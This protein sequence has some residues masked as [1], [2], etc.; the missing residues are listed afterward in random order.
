M[1]LFISNI[2]N[3]YTLHLETSLIHTSEMVPSVEPLHLKVY[4][5]YMDYPTDSSYVAM[6]EMPLEGAATGDETS[7]SVKSTLVRLVLTS[8]TFV[9]HRGQVHLA[10]E[11]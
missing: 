11:T 1:S 6:T 9:P 4:L 3:C 2:S 7:R 8:S 5:G 10:A